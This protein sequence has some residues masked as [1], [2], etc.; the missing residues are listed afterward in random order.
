MAD[1]GEAIGALI[2]LVLVVVVVAIIVTIIISLLTIILSI[3][4]ISG[5][6]FGGGTAISNYYHAFRNN[7]ALR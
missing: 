4:T 5:V 3:G 1:E 6:L 2:V 7:V